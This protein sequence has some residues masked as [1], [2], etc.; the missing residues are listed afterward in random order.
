VSVRPSKS[1]KAS[2]FWASG[3][4]VL[5]DQSFWRQQAHLLVG[6]VVAVLAFAPLSL[7]IQTLAIPLYY[8]AAGGVDLFGR[9][10]DTFRESLLAVPAGPRAAGRRRLSPRPADEALAG[11]GQTAAHRRS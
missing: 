11:A 1:S 4:A 7:G 2:G 9:S 10:I 8:D 3:F 6:W 5:R